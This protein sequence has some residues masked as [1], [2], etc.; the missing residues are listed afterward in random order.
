MKTVINFITITVLIIQSTV[1]GAFFTDRLTAYPPYI[2]NIVWLGSAVLGA[3]LGILF[4][5][6]HKELKV[7]VTTVAI[8]ALAG[9]IGFQFIIFG[10]WLAIVLLAAAAI[11]AHFYLHKNSKFTIVPVVSTVMG[12]FSILLFI[13]MKWI[14]AM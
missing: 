9:L 10:K 4:F 8:I 6:L 11:S 12:T 3:F 1:L 13:L 14:T 2:I 5:K 7:P